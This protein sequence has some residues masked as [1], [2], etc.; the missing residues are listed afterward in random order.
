MKLILVNP[1]LWQ[2][3]LAGTDQVLRVVC[4]FLI[5]FLST[6]HRGHKDMGLCGAVIRQR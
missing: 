6:R 5:S 4:V 1:D 3:G 2:S